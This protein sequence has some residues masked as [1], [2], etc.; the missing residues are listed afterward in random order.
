MLS[1]AV[2]A[3]H[4][5][6]ADHFFGSTDATAIHGQLAN[7]RL[8]ADFRPTGT[9]QWCLGGHRGLLRAQHPRRWGKL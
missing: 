4:K 1:G 8:R 3:L 5:E 7:R 9:I 2:D 6:E